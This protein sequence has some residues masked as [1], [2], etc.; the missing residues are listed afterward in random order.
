[1]KTKSDAYLS[2]YQSILK[3]KTEIFITRI[4]I[5]C[6]LW[7]SSI[8]F[9]V[10]MILIGEDK[11]LFC[12]KSICFHMNLQICL[13]CLYFSTEKILHFY[14]KFSYLFWIWQYHEYKIKIKIMKAKRNWSASEIEHQ[15]WFFI[16][17]IFY[18]DLA[19][20]MGKSVL[21]NLL[22]FI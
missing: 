7:N 21:E 12:S 1:M 22:A 20:K 5:K 6:I 4:P 9:H 2:K 19:I 10:L 15:H 13:H 3:K 14:H 11:K 8:Y 18:F 17:I 16:N